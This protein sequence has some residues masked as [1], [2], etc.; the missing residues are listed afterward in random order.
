MNSM[1]GVM[2]P[3][4]FANTGYLAPSANSLLCSSASRAFDEAY[5]LAN[6]EDNVKSLCKKLWAGRKGEAEEGR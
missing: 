5:P 4:L 2:T 1:H 6:A 3:V